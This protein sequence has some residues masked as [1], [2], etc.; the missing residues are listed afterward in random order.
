VVSG[1]D[2]RGY[3]EKSN[4]MLITKMR[5]GRVPQVRP[6]FGLTWDIPSTEW[7]TGSPPLPGVY[8]GAKYDLHIDDNHASH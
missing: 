5:T 8:I 7:R 3:A 2:C 1:I 6:S 4:V